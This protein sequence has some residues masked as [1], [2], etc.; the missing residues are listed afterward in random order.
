[1]ERKVSK[2]KLTALL[3]VLV[4]I[5]N[6]FAPYSVLAD[7]SNRGSDEPY[8]ELYLHPIQDITKIT[9][10]E[11]NEDTQNYYYDYWNYQPDY[12]DVETIDQS[13][14][15]LL[16]FDLIMKNVVQNVQTTS[17]NLKFDNSI[18]EAAYSDSWTTGGGRGQPIVNHKMVKNDVSELED[19]VE[20]G[21]W[22]GYGPANGYN[23]IDTMR[24]EANMLGKFVPEGHKLATFTMALKEG[25]TI[26]DVKT[27]LFNLV[28]VSGVPK[29]LQINYFP[30]STKVEVTGLD[31]LEFTGG[32][33]AD[34]TVKVSSINVKNGLTDNTY[35]NTE[36]IDFTGMELEIV[37][38]DGSKKT[39]TKDN[40]DAYLA[41]GTIFINNDE[42]YAK[43]DKKVTVKAGEK[44]CELPYLLPKELSITTDISKMQYE[45]GAN[46]EWAGGQ[47]TINYDDNTTEEVLDINQAITDG[48]LTPDRTLADVD[49][50][51]VTFTYIDGKVTKNQLVLIV[52]DPIV[53]IEISTMPIQTELEYDE[54]QTVTANTGKIRTIHKSGHTGANEI[55]M[56]D[57]KVTITPTTATIAECTNIRDKG[58]GTQ[59]GDLKISVSYLD[60]D[61]NIWTGYSNG[62]NNQ[63]AEY[64]VLVNDTISIVEVTTGSTAINK[65]GTLSTDLKLTGAEATITTSSGHTFTKPIDKGM[66]NFAGYNSTSLDEKEFVVSYGNV[67]TVAGKGLKLKLT[68]YIKDIE[69]TNTSIPKAN[70]NVEL[71]DADLANANVEYKP[72]YAD[73][74]KG[75]A[76]AVTANMVTDYKKNPTKPAYTYDNT[77]HIFT[78][79]LIIKATLPEYVGGADKDFTGTFTLNVVDTVSG[80]TVDQGPTKMVW[81]YGDIFD[82]AGM[83]IKR[84]YQSGEVDGTSISV[85]GNT[86]IS[87]TNLD[88][89][90]VTLTPEATEFD[91]KGR[92]EKEI[93]VTYIDPNT[94]QSLTTTTKV[95]VKDMLKEIAINTNP[96]NQLKDSFYHGEVFGIGNGKLDITYE[97]GR[98]NTVS[99]NSGTSFEFTPS[100]DAVST[101]P[102]ESEYT[103]ARR[104]YSYKNNSSRIYRRVNYKNCYI[105]NNNYKLYKYNENE[106]NSSTT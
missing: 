44:T 5:A 58:D 94:N 55:P 22:D 59:A 97:S 7:S 77:K 85:K 16:T 66:V 64:T 33:A 68:N 24:I 10:A 20:L 46:I 98:T 45:H 84:T 54:G 67:S 86:N 52:V 25:K 102:T 100:G 42:K 61:G 17:L 1:M 88:G 23:G 48:L 26:D 15:H 62:T 95:F 56:S 72:V 106:N 27:S 90:I 57:S 82:E 104:K 31:Y 101:E 40:M 38:S 92:A 13:K 32:F 19:F 4:I 87:V 80:I 21:K 91:S 30:T 96:E 93:K 47:V 105:P 6:L 81:N 39:V 53:G 65:Y 50:N 70:Y 63:P 12:P 73:G 18:L 43:A 29:G 99:L 103:S 11:W 49:N 51:T 60:P 34:D 78:E 14:V 75:V 8:I 76:T 37:Y 2:K 28:E 69:I 36:A 41:D 83:R 3:T 89:S 35:Y 79:N 9:E 74:S 71:T